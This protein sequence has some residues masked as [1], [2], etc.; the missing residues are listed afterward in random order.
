MIPAVTTAKPT[1]SKKLMTWRD[2]A[3]VESSSLPATKNWRVHPPRVSEA[4]QL[5]EVQPIPR[6]IAN[7]KLS[8]DLIRF[9]DT[10]RALSATDTLTLIVRL[11]TTAD[12]L[13][14]WA[15][16]CNL[17]KREIAPALR[18]PANNE[19][20]QFEFIN[21]AADLLW[22][23]KRNPNHQPAYRGWRGVFTNSPASQGWHATV[24]RQYIYLYSRYALSF[25]T[26]KG[27]ALDEAQRQDLMLLKT[28]AMQA[29][30][31]QLD[32]DRFAALRE[33]LLSLAID[34]PDKAGLHRP[35]TVANRRAALWRVIILSGRKK[36]TTTRNW[37]RLTNET[38][39]R[40]AVANQLA[41]V[42]DA[43]RD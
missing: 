1:L 28:N 27:L 9:K 12:P 14:L 4:L 8:D 10:V 6:L 43:L 13:V 15:I 42:A 25:K 21:Y 29:D 37:Q 38:L 5:D 36:S 23:S 26:A 33:R 16:H 32:P 39:T 19:G 7:K 18:W 22:F 31:R 2:G 30:R 17:D 34:R 40:Q 41:I 35:D 24:Y 20:P 3:S 11:A